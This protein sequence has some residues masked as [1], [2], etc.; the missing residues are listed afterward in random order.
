MSNL[1]PITLIIPSNEE[2]LKLKDLL[3]AVLFWTK[4][5]SEIII[6]DNS[7]KKFIIDK[8]IKQ[9]YKKKKNFIKSFL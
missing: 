8:N 2:S 9:I 6:S 7:Q 5:P 4:F 1:L 3:R